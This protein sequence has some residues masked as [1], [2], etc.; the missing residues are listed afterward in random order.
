MT[1]WR[2]LG[3]YWAAWTSLTSTRTRPCPNS[4]QTISGKAAPGLFV[5]IGRE[6][7]YTLAQVAIQAKA[8]RNHCLVIGS[9]KDVAD[10][11]ELWFREGAAD[12]FNLLPAIVPGS[13]EDFCGLVVPELQ[14][15]GLFKTDYVGSTLRENMGLVAS[16]TAHARIHTRITNAQLA[17]CQS[18]RALAA[19]CVI[20]I[21]C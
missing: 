11:M 10:H 1:R 19:R 13:L 5:R 20:A 6:N 3:G 18:G 16:L 21:S 9:A 2:G 17:A 15:R 7:N 12:G 14:S 8:A 4:L